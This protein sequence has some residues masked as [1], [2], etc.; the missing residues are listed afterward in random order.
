[1]ATHLLGEKDDAESDK[2]HRIFLL[3]STLF[4]FPDGCGPYIMGHIKLAI[5]YK[6]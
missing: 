2:N 1:M 3:K 5:D 4:E 6:L